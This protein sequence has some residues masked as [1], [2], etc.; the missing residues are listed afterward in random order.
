MRVIH[1]IEEILLTTTFAG[2]RHPDRHHP[3]LRRL[4][5]LHHLH[6]RHHHR[7]RH[8]HCPRSFSPH[9]PSSRLQMQKIIGL[10]RYLMQEKHQCLMIFC[11]K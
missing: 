11:F 9:P 2:H 10:I 5:Y 6:L 7:L 3:H 1:K 4:H 8:P